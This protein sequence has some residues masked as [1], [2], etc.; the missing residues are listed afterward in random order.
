MVGP[1]L[2]LPVANALTSHIL[3]LLLSK[4]YTFSLLL[5][6]QSVKWP[7]GLLFPD[8][9]MIGSLSETALMFVS[10]SFLLPL[11]I[12]PLP[13]LCFLSGNPQNPASVP[14]LW[15]SLQQV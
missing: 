6:I 14:L 5:Q 3:E 9:S 4:I 10:S 8:P 1:L 15:F 13:V 12:F 7:L 2:N 11:E